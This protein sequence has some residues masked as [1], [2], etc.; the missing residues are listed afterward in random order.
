MIHGLVPA[1][2]EAHNIGYCVESMLNAGCD[3]V[4]VLDGAYKCADGSTFMG[5]GFESKDGTG[6]I[7]EQAGATVF[8]PD[9]QPRF[10]EKR[11]MLLELCGAERG[12]HVLFM[13]ADERAVGRISDD[14]PWGHACVLLRNL[15]PNDLPDLR[16]E[17]P[18][19][20]AGPVVPL[21][22]FLRWSP[23]LRFVG[24]G[25]FEQGGK[26][27]VPYLVQAFGALVGDDPV[28]LQALAAVRETEQ[29]LSPKLA[30]ALPL[31]EG[32]EIHHVCEQTPERVAAKRKAYA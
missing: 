10:G 26:P 1:F 30:C 23:D 4:T 8:V 15:K 3:K 6:E 31:L 17:W 7:A 32:L 12:D 5:G 18:R 19:G 14:P 9:R 27:I 2:E 22:R 25:N 13:D 16:G 11:Q 24:S 21:L 29:H 28:L 20:D